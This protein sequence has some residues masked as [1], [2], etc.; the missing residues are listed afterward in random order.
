MLLHFKNVDLKSKLSNFK[1]NRTKI[2]EV[3]VESKLKLLYQIRGNITSEI[4][5]LYFI[6]SRYEVSDI[7]KLH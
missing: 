7:L 2:I 6:R 4:E 5:C 1:A 3:R